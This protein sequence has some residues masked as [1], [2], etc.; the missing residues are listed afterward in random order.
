MTTQDD[1]QDIG[2]IALHGGRLGL[3]ALPRTPAHRAALAAHTPSVI[4][5]LTEDGEWP[6]VANAPFAGTVARHLRF[7][8]PD[9][10]TPPPDADWLSLST[11]LQ[12]ALRDAGTVIIHCWGGRGRSGMIALRLMIEAG[13]NPVDALARLRAARPGAVETAEQELWARAA[14]GSAERVQ[15]SP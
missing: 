3:T 2:W 12:A 14:P 7:P 1:A 9:Y 8:I 13:E 15:S 11:T 6:E 10:G 5:S 4:L